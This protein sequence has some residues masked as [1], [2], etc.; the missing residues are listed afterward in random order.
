L[1]KHRTVIDAALAAAGVVRTQLD[2]LYNAVTGL[3][4]GTSFGVELDQY[5]PYEALLTI[6][7]Q[8]IYARRAVDLPVKDAW[9]KGYRILDAKGRDEFYSPEWAAERKRLKLQ[10]L[11]PR[12]VQYARM[13]RSAYLVAVT[14]DGST[15]DRPL[16]L[17][18]LKR[19]DQFVLLSAGEC[20]PYKR[21]LTT[22]TADPN[23]DAPADFAAPESYVVSIPRPMQTTL[24]GVPAKWAQAL[25]G[26]TPIHAS[27]IIRVVNGN[28]TLTESYS[29]LDEG[30]SLIGIIFRV[31]AQHATLDHAAATL[32]TEMRQHI[33]TI[34]N[35]QAI[36]ASNQSEP[37]TER[38]RLFAASKTV[39]NL[40]LL[41]KG[42]KFES[43]TGS[44]GGF[45]T[46][47][48]TT[49]DA[50]CAATGIPESIFFPKASGGMGGEPGIDA[51][52]YVA[53]LRDIWDELLGP[54]VA[55]V[56]RFL[57]AQKN[58][59]WRGI[60]YKAAIEVV[61]RELRELK[62]KERATL[63]LLTAQADTIYLGSGSVPREYINLRFQDPTGWRENLP[64]YDPEKWPLPPLPD[65]KAKAGGTPNAEGKNGPGQT[66]ATPGE[67]VGTSKGST[68]GTSVE[69]ANGVQTSAGDA[70]GDNAGDNAA[71]WAAQ[72]DALIQTTIAALTE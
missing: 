2:A 69:A 29:Q 67:A 24:R 36:K 10:R 14:V 54:T 5:V 6:Y 66:P 19:V 7:R 61:P 25:S 47:A 49:R 8:E 72:N 70:A 12:A 46:L 41:G 27:R 65:P 26:Q 34:E 52:V 56:R 40:I 51:E 55:D 57:V 18:T 60:G 35:M 28:L 3:G 22:G 59:P 53:L 50:L 31:L 62:P 37:F 23:D 30:E 63:R 48:Q 33:V 64:E 11:I 38:M 39:A 4:A 1:A 58:G 21:A 45:D 68:A 15:P 71:T 43:A 32:A 13:G 16:D 44:V 17:G 42:E 20:R 9:A